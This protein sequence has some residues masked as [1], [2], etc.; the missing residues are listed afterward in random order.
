MVNNKNTQSFL[1]SKQ[2]QGQDIGIKQSMGDTNLYPF[3]VRDGEY[4][5][6]VVPS[7]KT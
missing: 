4:Y 7:F 1:K 5:T 2:C 3:W 6:S